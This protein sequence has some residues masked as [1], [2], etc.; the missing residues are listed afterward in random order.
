MAVELS[1][2]QKRQ[3]K[4]LFVEKGQREAV[5]YLLKHFNLSLQQAQKVI[6]ELDFSENSP[7]GTNNLTTFK[8]S[9]G[10]LLGNLMGPIFILIG[11]AMTFGAGYIFY[12][13]YLFSKTAVSVNGKVIDFATSY[14][15]IG[16]DDENNKQEPTIMYSSVVEF[17]YEAHTYKYTSKLASSSPDYEINEEVEILINPTSPE[18][19]Q[20][21]E[22][23]DRWRSFVILMVMGIGFTVAGYFGRSRS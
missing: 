5:N 7:I 8:K 11:I 4:S 19:A 6:Q 2:D 23:S 18:Q 22:F 20:I 3:L 13:N 16:V 15:V 12:K 1:L 14:R 9:K 17:K 21:N 10:G